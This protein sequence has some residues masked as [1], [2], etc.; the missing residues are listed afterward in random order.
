M[1]LLPVNWRASARAASARC[2]LA[3]AST[4]TAKSRKSM[5]KF[6]RRPPRRGPEA[7]G[8]LGIGEAR[9]RLSLR[10]PPSLALLLSLRLSSPLSLAA[11]RRRRRQRRSGSAAGLRLAQRHVENREP[12][13]ALDDARWDLHSADIPITRIDGF[14]DHVAIQRMRHG[15]LYPL[16]EVVATK[17]RRYVYLSNALKRGSGCSATSTSRR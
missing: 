5:T 13:L 15:G 8:K 6:G 4:T 1:G 2:G 11:R 7:G 9:R 16:D 3:G 17:R 14:Q 12:A 10:L